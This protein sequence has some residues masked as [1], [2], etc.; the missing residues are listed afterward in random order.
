[1]AYLDFFH[2]VPWEE[3]K[4]ISRIQ[5]ELDWDYPREL[6]STWRFGCRIA[7]L[8]DYMYLMSLGVTEKDG[9]Y[10]KNDTGR[11]NI[12]GRRLKAAGLRTPT[13]HAYDSGTVQ[14]GG[15]Q[16]Y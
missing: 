4:V 14:P 16:A 15:H 8:K 13:V 10:A 1:M 2:Y 3:A 7:H 9:F 12:P 5:E 11:T 6:P